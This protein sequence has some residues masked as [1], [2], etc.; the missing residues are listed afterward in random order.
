MSPLWSKQ[1]DY[2]NK[3]PLCKYIFYTSRYL[4]VEYMRASGER[5]QEVPVIAIQP[6]TSEETTGFYQL[7]TAV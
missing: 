3:A 5:E 7:T 2:Q 4:Y 1:L 6:V